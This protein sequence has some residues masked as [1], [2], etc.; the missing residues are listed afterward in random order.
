ML[1]F[2]S[3][4]TTSRKGVLIM[5]YFLFMLTVAASL[6]VPYMIWFV[7]LMSVLHFK[8]LTRLA[9]KLP[10]GVQIGG[11][12]LLLVLLVPL[13]WAFAKDPVQATAWMGI[14]TLW[15]SFKEHDIRAAG[16][17]VRVATEKLSDDVQLQW[18][19]WT[20]DIAP[21]N[22]SFAQ[23]AKRARRGKA[24]Y[25]KLTLQ[26]PAVNGNYTYTVHIE[27]VWNNIVVYRTT[28]SITL[29]VGEFNQVNLSMPPPPS[30]KAP[31]PAPAPIQIPSRTKYTA[32]APTFVAVPA[33]ILALAMPTVIKPHTYEYYNFIMNAFNRVH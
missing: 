31:V 25:Y 11:T 3:L 22:V 5:D 8:T 24:A 12:V 16:N 17:Y 13:G 27:C 7:L 10:W 14:P 6:Y 15:P 19:Y 1:M 4:E 2:H 26:V 28:Q 18:R 23:V 33:N 21:I 30:N 9:T 29:I 20:S 32:P